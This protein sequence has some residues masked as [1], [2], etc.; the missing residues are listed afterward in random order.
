MFNFFFSFF[1]SIKDENGKGLT[2]QEIADEVDTFMFEGHDTTASGISW[3][4]YNLAKYPDIQEQ[5]RREILMIF[6]EKDSDNVEWYYISL[7]RHNILFFL[8]IIPLSL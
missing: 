7:L 6:E 1:Q 5:C 8:S 4:L 2:D 3:C